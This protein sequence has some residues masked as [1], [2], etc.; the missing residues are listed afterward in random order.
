MAAFAGDDLGGGFSLDLSYQRCP[1]EIAPV[2]IHAP[3]EVGGLA[4]VLDLL[5]KSGQDARVLNQIPVQ[6]SR[7][8]SHCPDDK[9][10]G[11]DASRSSEH[12]VSLIKFAP[13][14]PVSNDVKGMV[15]HCSYS[16]GR[17]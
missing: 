7:A 5:G 17:R 14:D 3:I 9:E 16:Y 10:I 12:S 4:E 6:R 15:I 2:P 8:A 1:R 11:Q 13:L